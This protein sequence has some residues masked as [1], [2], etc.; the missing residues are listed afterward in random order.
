[1]G[2]NIPVYLLSNDN[3]IIS[4]AKI[5]YILC[6]KNTAWYK[7][8]NDKLQHNKRGTSGVETSDSNVIISVENNRM[9]AF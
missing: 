2:K 1:M 5:Q 8:I 4:P 3:P 6:C 9:S 7:T